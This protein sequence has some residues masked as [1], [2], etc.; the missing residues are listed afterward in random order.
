MSSGVA[1][2]SLVEL[3]G[4]HAI[5]LTALRL[6]LSVNE[7]FFVF[8]S[9]T[10]TNPPVPPVARM[11]A[12]FKFHA[13]HS[14]SSERAAAVPKRKAFSGSLTSYTKSSPL[15][16]AVAKIW[17]LSGLNCRDLMAPVCFVVRDIGASESPLASFS[18]SQR[19]REPFSRAPAMMPRG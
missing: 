15:A 14:K 11:W 13:T 8:K 10:V 5:E 3:L 6:L 4:S 9:Q 16:P 12:T 7:A 17:G 18:A 2:T 1:V 19:S